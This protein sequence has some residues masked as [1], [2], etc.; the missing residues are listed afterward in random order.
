MTTTYIALLHSIVITRDRRVVMADLKAMAL[1]LGFAAP[2]TWVASGNLVFEAEDAPLAALE[3]RLESAFAARFG[4][5]VD[6]IMRRAED[7]RLLV[8]ANPFPD[9]AE[10]G[11]DSVHVRVMRHP[12]PADTLARLASYLTKGER[13]AVIGGDLWMH[14]PG[15]PSESRLLPLL[16]PKRT[17]IG[18]TRNWNTV[19]QLGVMIDA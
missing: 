7:W 15:K 9:E 10:S 5:H 8:A 11:A 12:L 4:R 17:G 2:R 1:E 18:T 6:I 3:G 13:V 16:T 14:F 19:R